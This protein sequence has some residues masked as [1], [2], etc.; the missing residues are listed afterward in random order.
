[1]WWGSGRVRCGGCG[2]VL[3]RDVQRSG[4]YL[5]CHSRRRGIDCPG[6]AS[7]RVD[8]VEQ[9]VV[10]ALRQALKG[11]RLPG[12]RSSEEDPVAARQSDLAAAE[13][14]LGEGLAESIRLGLSARERDSLVTSLRAD[15]RAAEMAL[16]D[17]TRRSAVTPDAV[18]S[19][20]RLATELADAWH[21]LDADERRA[22]LA[23]LDVQIRVDRGG[24]VTLLAPWRHA[25]HSAA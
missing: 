24:S 22:A 8:I 14:R 9:R 23:A 11:L 12:S 1:M 13:A 6:I 10:V 3:V 16:A 17:A 19:V 2:F 18:V 7:P 5:R 20:R 4:E 21:E 25:P 15:V